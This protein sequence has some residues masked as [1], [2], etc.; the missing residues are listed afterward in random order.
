MADPL[1]PWQRAETALATDPAGVKG[2]WLRARPLR[3]RITDALPQP[4]HP[5]QHRRHCPF[6]RRRPVRHP[7]IRP[8]DPHSG[9]PRQHRS[10]AADDGRTLPPPDLSARLA[11]WL[12][13]PQTCLIALDEGADPDES[14]P[15]ALTDRLGLFLD[16]SDTPYSDTHPITLNPDRI[17]QARARLPHTT[18]P[19]SALSSITTVAAAMGIASLRDPPPH[20]RHCPSAGRVAR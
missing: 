10:P 17:A 15:A 3:D 6:R 9:P 12:D 8:P 1:T 20:P 11:R 7:L 18:L 19:K 16:L 4:P 13:D 5:P 2:P 14:L